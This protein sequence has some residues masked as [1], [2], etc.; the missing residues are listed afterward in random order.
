MIK[1]FIP[2]KQ[3]EKT[4]F[5]RGG[6]LIPLFFLLPALVFLASCGNDSQKKGAGPGGQAAQVKT[7]PRLCS[8][9]NSTARHNNAALS[10]T[11]LT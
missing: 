11:P 2:K 3:F 1:T 6:Q 5:K 4:L 10:N 7:Y 8:A 9:E